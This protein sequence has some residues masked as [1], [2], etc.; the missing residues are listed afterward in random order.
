MLRSAGTTARG[1]ACV[2]WRRCVSWQVH[3]EFG[4]MPHTLAAGFD[5][6]SVH[7]DQTLD[8]CQSDSETAFAL[9]QAVV[10]LCKKIKHIGQ[11]VRWDTNPV[12]LD[13]K[14]DRLVACFGVH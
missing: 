7:F 12:I 1:N 9:G 13:G 4:S 8:Q 2:L 5:A 6:A 3:Q 14:G 10:G 11:D